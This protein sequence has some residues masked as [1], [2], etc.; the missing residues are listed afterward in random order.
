VPEDPSTAVVETHLAS[1]E[2]NY[3]DLVAEFT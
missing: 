1:L 3:A 2:G